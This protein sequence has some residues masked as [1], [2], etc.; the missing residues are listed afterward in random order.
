MSG[1]TRAGTTRVGHHK[2]GRAYRCHFTGHP[3]HSSLAPHGANAIEA[4]AEFVLLLR[5][6]A[7]DLADG[8]KDADFDLVHSTLSVG[9]ISGGTAINIVPAGATVTLEFRNLAEVDQEAIFRRIEREVHDRILLGLRQRFAGAEAW[10]EPIHGYSA[11]AIAADD[12]F[13]AQMKHI[14]GRNDRS[15]VAFGAVAI[16]ACS[17]FGQDRVRHRLAAG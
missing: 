4:A 13:V 16:A 11:H 1:T 2:G 6:V 14:V 8:P 9:M 15:K 10:F 7:A 3:V 17:R 5:Q 12:P